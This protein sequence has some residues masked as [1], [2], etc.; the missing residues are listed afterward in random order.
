MHIRRFIPGDE[1]FLFSVYFSAIHDIAS[2]DYSPDEINAWAPID[3]YWNLWSR[4]MC[5]INPFVAVLDDEIVGYAD[6]QSD[7]YI[8][9]F[10]VSGTRPRQG[11]G[12]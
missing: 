7:G 12:K 5:G 3:V 1:A 6:V 8:D 11:I 4:R 9:H 2:R 10:F